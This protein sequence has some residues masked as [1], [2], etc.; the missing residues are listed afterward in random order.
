MPAG[1]QIVVTPVVV[2]VMMNPM[3]ET[4]TIEA[5]VRVLLT[6]EEEE[7]EEQEGAQLNER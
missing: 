3:T 5:M 2:K 7:N 1:G 6:V 4:I